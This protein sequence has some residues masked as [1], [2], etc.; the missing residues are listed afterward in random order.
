MAC[1]L[2]LQIPTKV[3]VKFSWSNPHMQFDFALSFVKLF[4]PWLEICH[5]LMIKIT[6]TST[7]MLYFYH[8]KIAIISIH[9]QNKTPSSIMSL[10]PRLSSRIWAIQK[11]IKDAY[12]K[13][14]CH[15]PKRHDKKKREKRCIHKEG[16]PHV[17]KTCRKKEKKKIYSLCPKKYK[18]R[19]RSCKG[20]HPLST[21][22]IPHTC[23]TWSDCMTHSCLDL[24]IDLTI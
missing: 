13:K 12:P 8:W 10:S 23:T 15:M 3:K 24:V 5:T 18:E 14:V 21:K 11:E 9:S 2:K 20:V 17:H 19:D 4:D 22:N 1:L 7:H 6:Y 16:M